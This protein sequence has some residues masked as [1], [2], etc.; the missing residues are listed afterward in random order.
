MRGPEPIAAIVMAAGRGTRLRSKAPKFLVE[1]N[2]RPMVEWVLAAIRGLH[3]RL[4]VVVTPPDTKHVF[5]DVVVA[6][7]E[8][9]LGTANAVAAARDALQGFKGDVLVLPA[10]TPLI[11]TA[12]LAGL[13]RSHRRLR[14]AVTVLSFE[15]PEPLPYGR[16]VRGPDGDLASI[17]EEGDA[18]PDQRR[19]RELNASIY[20]FTSEWLW[21]SISHL[22]NEN[23]KCELQ[24]TS[25]IRRIVASGGVAAAHT[26]PDPAEAV[27]VN[28]PEDLSFAGETLRQRRRSHPLHGLPSTGS[29]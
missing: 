24:L 13:V 18:T 8:Q 19:I 9:P 5:V 21:N 6:V 20:A 4:I 22:D 10:D 3:P 25:G 16:I 23:A 2:G 15:W 28:T 26:A 17:V 27:G 12:T 7:Q 1:L 29:G 14:P 11:T